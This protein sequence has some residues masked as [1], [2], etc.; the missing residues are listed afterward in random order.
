MASEG[1][2][3]L[4]VHRDKYGGGGAAERRIVALNAEAVVDRRDIPVLG[5]PKQDHKRTPSRGPR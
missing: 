4:E 1:G 2:A 5:D 3:H